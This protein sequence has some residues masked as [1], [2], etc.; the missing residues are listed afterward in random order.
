[1]KMLLR[2]ALFYFIFS[3]TFCDFITSAAVSTEELQRGLSVSIRE[4]NPLLLPSCE[5]PRDTINSFTQITRQ[6]GDVFENASAHGDLNW[7]KEKLLINLYGQLEMLLDVSMLPDQDHFARVN[8]IASQLAEI[9][10][11]IPLPPTNEIPDKIKIEQNKIDIWRI[12][13]TEIA[14][15]RTTEPHRLGDWVFAPHTVKKVG[16]LYKNAKELPYRQ[17]ANVGSIKDR[18]GLLEHY[19]TYTGPLIP[20][21]LTE[22]VPDFLRIKWLG[23]NLWKYLGTLIVIAVLLLFAWL[24][25]KLT[26]FPSDSNASPHKTSLALRRMILPLFLLLALQ[27]SIHLI[28][29]DLRLR[30][31]PLQITDDMLWGCFYVVA[32]WLCVCVGNLLSALLVSSSSKV[33]DKGIDASLIRLFIRILANIAGLWIVFEGLKELGVSLVPLI[34]GASVGGLAFALAVKPTLSNIIGG[35]MIFADQPFKVGDHI[36]MDKHDGFVEDIGLRS[37]RIRTLS[38]HLVTIPNEYISDRDIINISKRPYILRKLNIGLTYDT[39]PEKIAKSMQII[40]QLLS[41]EEDQGKASEELGRPDNKHVNAAKYPPRVYFDELNADSLNILILY[42]FSPPDFW[43]FNEYNTW[44]NQQLVD[45][46]NRAGI[47]FAF[48]TQTIDLKTSGLS[49]ADPYE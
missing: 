11:R 3:I 37:T 24:V 12:P 34:A 43:S 30:L 18:G 46:F 29:I 35:V 10:D 6:I 33:H 4:S 36:I 1:M 39:P 48:P 7:E 44:F 45:R 14:L 41:L 15:T 21:D 27:L 17:D 28:T 20:V 42:W 16:H 8:I 40:E 38:G 19:I 2:I 32:Y 5:S 22:N 13:N 47:S 9:L 25:Y 23:I 49:S 26:R 31:I